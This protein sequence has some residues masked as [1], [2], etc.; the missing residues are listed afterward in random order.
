M[1]GQ[2]AEKPVH[3]F[4][5][6]LY[7]IPFLGKH[8]RDQ[9]REAHPTRGNAPTAGQ[10]AAASGRRWRPRSAAAPPPAS[11]VLASA[12]R[13]LSRSPA[14]YWTIGRRRRSRT[15]P[16][17]IA[18]ARL[19]SLR[20]RVD[21]PFDDVDPSRTAGETQTQLPVLDLPTVTL[22]CVDTVNHALA[23]R[24]LASSTA[25]IRFARVVFLTAAV[26][27]GLRV[28]A[29]I[30]VRAIAPLASR[31]AYSNFVLKD[32]LAHVATEHVLVAQWDGYVVNP[33]AWSPEFL[34]CDY[35]GAAWFWRDDAMQVGNGGFSLRSRRLLA[36]LQDPRITLTEAEDTTICRA[37]RGLLEREYGIRFGEVSAAERFSFETDYPVGR[38]FG[39]HGLFNFWRVVPRPSLRRSHRMFPTALRVR[40]SSTSCCTTAYSRKCGRRQP[41]SRAAYWRPRPTARKRGYC[42]WTPR[43]TLLVWARS[44]QGIPAHAEAALPSPIVTA[45]LARPLCST[46]RRGR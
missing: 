22:A 37:Y 5:P 38:P 36:A 45:R 11:Q 29:G 12:E 23:L 10:P 43:R 33:Q 28:P 27:D 15:A 1:A 34:D 13:R 44:A 8:D 31:D 21:E 26:P 32:L 6:P 25:G 41:P 2:R 16:D 18:L 46:Y 19:Q 42:L 24:A 39:F 3:S 20:K 4:N 7:A 9:I 17:G 14:F 30:E 35:L 40:R